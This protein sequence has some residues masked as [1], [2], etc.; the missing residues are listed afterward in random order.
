MAVM[1]R[2][3]RAL[4][5]CAV[6]AAGLGSSASA[7]SRQPGDAAAPPP[8]PIGTV[9]VTGKRRTEQEIIRTVIAPFVARH[10]ARDAKT[11]LLVRGPPEGVCPITLGLSAGFNDFV[12]ARVVAVA[13]SVG[14]VVQ[15]IGK[16]RPNVQVVFTTDAQGFVNQMVEKS[17]GAILGFHVV[18]QERALI[19]VSRPIQ[20]WYVTGTLNAVPTSF[21]QFVGTDPGTMGFLG[22]VMMDR[23]DGSQPYS[24]LGSRLTPRN[25]SQ[26]MNVLI[27]ADLDKL[28]GHEVG[29]VSDYIAMLALSQAPSLDACGELPSILDL[30]ASDCPGRAKPQALTD[31]DMAFLKALYAA[32]ITIS[33]ARGRDRVAH[34]MVQ[35]LDG[36][37]P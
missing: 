3:L 11:G 23:N 22:G 14:A 33:G 21:V 1:V 13:K 27:V 26:I 20:A 24:G 16:C 34:G 25:S 31:S 37:A 5:L 12:T 6:L 18:G 10:A 30:M 7:Q 36:A 17:R 19:H 9:T 4:M 8:K 28:D 32:D 15:R 35:A 2:F 29:P